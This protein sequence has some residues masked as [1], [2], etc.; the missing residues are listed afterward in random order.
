MASGCPSVLD[1]LAAQ[2]LF[3]D[4]MSLPYG[5]D[6]DNQIDVDKSATR[7]SVWTKTL[8]SNEMPALDRRARQ[9]LWRTTRPTSSVPRAPARLWC[10]VPRPAKHRLDARRD[11]DRPRRNFLRPHLRAAVVADRAHEP[12]P[13]SRTG[14]RGLGAHEGRRQDHF[15]VANGCCRPVWSCRPR[16]WWRLSEAETGTSTTKCSPKWTAKH[17]HVALCRT[18]RSRSGNRSHRGC[19]CRG[20]LDSEE[21]R[22]HVA[23][24]R[25][26]G[27]HRLPPPAL[28]LQKRATRSD[29]P[30]TQFRPG[31]HGDGSVGICGRRGRSRGVR[32]YRDSVRYHRGRHDSLHDQVCRSKKERVVAVGVRSIGVS[33][34]GQGAIGDYGGVRTGI[35]GVRS[36]GDDDQPG[37]RP[38]RRSD[39]HHCSARGFP[40]PP[41]VADDAR[42]HQGNE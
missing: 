32:R 1:D 40:V 3:L 31:R 33:L 14:L 25:R 27:G 10:F 12:R 20:Q 38:A 21:H 2:Y 23:R 39:R 6:L 28:R 37:A 8:S 11:H 9:W 19:G 5:I 4:E 16:G 15:F 42:R 18:K 22:G 17:V 30:D 41:A 35:H 26:G 34:G 24:H 13:E 29:Q 7:M 36:V